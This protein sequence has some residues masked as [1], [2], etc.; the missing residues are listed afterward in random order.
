MRSRPPSHTERPIAPNHAFSE[1]RERFGPVSPR[2]SGRFNAAGTRLNAT[3][4]QP[5]SNGVG[6]VPHLDDG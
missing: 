4:P 5:I 2:R 3:G 6:D 1:C